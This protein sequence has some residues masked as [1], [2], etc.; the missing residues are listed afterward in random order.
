MAQTLLYSR[1]IGKAWKMEYGITTGIKKWG[2][3][4][5]YKV[6][7]GNP[8]KKIAIEL[9]GIGHQSPTSRKR[10][11]KK[12]RILRSLG[13][14]VLRFWNWEILNWIDSGTPK[15]NS[16]YTICKSNGIRLSRSK[17]S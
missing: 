7:L 11:Q 12:E 2:V 10:D 6:D 3:S 8:L 1:L 16:I 17:V 14:K 9:D 15:N 5:C 4:A 13:W